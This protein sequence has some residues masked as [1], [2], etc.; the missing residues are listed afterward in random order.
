MAATAA[1]TVGNQDITTGRLA[2]RARGHT[3]AGVLPLL[4]G[5]ATIFC[6][7]ACL[8]NRNAWQIRIPTAWQSIRA[9]A[10][11][12]GAKLLAGVSP[13]FMANWFFNRFRSRIKRIKS[14]DAEV[15]FSANY[16]KELLGKLTTRG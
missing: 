11:D 12:R 2:V 4:A 15:S 8:G 10:L 14:H 9:L 1:D 3:T 13:A 5:Q 7:Q 16:M 6:F